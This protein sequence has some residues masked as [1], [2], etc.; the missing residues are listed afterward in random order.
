[1]FFF[2]FFP[3]F[4][5][6][7]AAS[8]QY[9]LE[10]WASLIFLVRWLFQFGLPKSGRMSS[11]HNKY[12]HRSHCIQNVMFV[13]CCALVFFLNFS[14]FSVF[15]LFLTIR[16]FVDRCFCCCRCRCHCY[17]YCNA[18]RMCSC[19][20]SLFIIIAI[21]IFIL[22]DFTSSSPRTDIRRL[23]RNWFFCELNIFVTLPRN[24]F[25]A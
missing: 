24:M 8:S 22:L 9:F 21:F 20:R 7:V 25:I 23:Y 18:R 16:I 5:V 11:V 4:V 19:V 14:S 17:C 1:M 13:C 12:V 3:I 6:V 2:V 10:S 15:S